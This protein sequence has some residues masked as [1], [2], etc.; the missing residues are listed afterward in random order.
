[1]LDI[2]KLV[3][4]IFTLSFISSSY[5][6]DVYVGYKFGY[7]KMN[8]FTDRRVEGV[9]LDLVFPK[10]KLGIHYELLWGRRYFRM[11]AGPYAGLVVAG[12]IASDTSNGIGASLF[13]GL[14]FA[15]IPEGISYNAYVHK[16]FDFAPYISP[17]QIVDINDKG[18]EYATAMAGSLGARFN[19]YASNRV[20]RFSPFIEGQLLYKKGDYIGLSFGAT[21]SLRL[22]SD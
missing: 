19:F 18:E 17:L 22:K 13:L 2:I 1:M 4:I 15:A 20:F 16:S 3:V 5:G 9:Q 10:S 21:A 12:R 7:L 6:Q 8:N 14:L 11:Y